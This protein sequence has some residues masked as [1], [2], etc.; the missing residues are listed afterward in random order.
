MTFQNILIPPVLYSVLAVVVGA[1]VVLLFTSRLTRNTPLLV[2]IGFVSLV[3]GAIPALRG[4]GR[5]LIA[6]L[7]IA[8]AGAVAMLLLATVE[9]EEPSQRP[10]IAALVLLGAGGGMAFATAG[11]LLAAVVALET[12]SLAG[13]I[14]VALGRG[15][16]TLEA[17]FKLFVISSISFATML[18][19]VGLIFLATVE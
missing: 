1:L 11:D 8:A 4:D 2:T 3:V 12:L 17:A 13:A 10:E 14:M 6:V 7:G 16:R 18:Y 9:L 15:M 19:G 5:T